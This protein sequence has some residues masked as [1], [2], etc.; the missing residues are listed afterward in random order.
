MSQLDTFAAELEPALNPSKRAKR[1]A[2]VAE[3]PSTPV[4]RITTP[5][6][7]AQAALQV[8]DLMAEISEAT[9]RLHYNWTHEAL[10]LWVNELNAMASGLLSDVCPDCGLSRGKSKGLAYR[11]RCRKGTEES[12]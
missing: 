9:T 1:A 4:S 7:L 10:N 3:I 8:R 6:E 2:R 11:C 12:E 5:V